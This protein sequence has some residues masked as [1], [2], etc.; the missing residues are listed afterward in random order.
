MVHIRTPYA[1][2][3][4]IGAEYNRQMEL[5]PDG[6][7]A[8]FIDGDIMFLNSNFGNI[9]HE[10]HTAY[11]DSLLTCFTNRTHKVST[12]QQHQCNSI[13]V[14]E[15]LRVADRIKDDRTVTEL[16]GPVS[17]LLMVIPKSVWLKHKF[18]ESNQFRPGEVN[19]L[20]VDNHYTNT[21]RANGVKVLRMNGLFM[22]HQYRLLT[23][24]KTHLL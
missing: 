12:G 9:L 14:V 5:I 17:M 18:C 10:Y 22:Y 11:P 4:N 1:L 16:T 3:K 19:L 7:A 24:T 15:C 8:C 13:D 6:D 20:G 23:G 2:D 21:V